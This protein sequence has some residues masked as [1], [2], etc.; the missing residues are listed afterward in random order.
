MSEQ[1]T[2][3]SIRLAL[4]SGDSRVFRQ[5]V[6]LAWSGSSVVRLPNGKVLIEDARPIHVGLCKGSSDLIGWKTVTITPDMVGSQVAVFLAVEVKGPKTRISPEQTNF[7]D[8]VA[9][10]GGLA[11]IARSVEDALKIT[12]HDR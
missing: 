8:R 9:S 2:Q 6:G 7:I 12:N 4:S 1:N 11:G 3:Q 5:N 10:A